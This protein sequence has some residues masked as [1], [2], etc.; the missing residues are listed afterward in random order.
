[1]DAPLDLIA[2]P[3]GLAARPATID[4]LDAVVALV[5]ACEEHDTGRAELDPEDLVADWG[6]PGMDLATM[7]V[8]VFAGDALVAEAD[9][10]HGRA[11]V[12]IHPDHRGRGIGTA[13]LPWLHAVARSQG[14]TLRQLAHDTDV[15][16]REF[17]LRHGYRETFTSWVLAI[18]LEGEIEPPALPDGI[19]F[20]DFRSGID[21]RET[22]QVIEDAFSEWEGRAPTTFED[23]VGLTIG[24]ESFDPSNMLLA[25]DEATDEIA[26]VVFMIDYGI[27]D[28]WIQQVATKATHRHRGIARAMLHRAFQ[29]YGERGKKT[30][31]LS[32]DSRT[33]AL[34]LYEKVGMRVFS[35]Y[36]NYVKDLHEEAPASIAR[37]DS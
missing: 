10:S 36:T 29:V 8:A 27:E 30:V 34:G 7:S 31:E 12:N 15:D 25:V 2:L 32:T 1:M 13:I 24:R 21:D 37:S 9:T 19:A 4:D 11:E 28:G 22:Y 18:S 17:L 16:R 6:R 20:R 26:G 33:G 5:R 14:P 35:S 23:W 3:A